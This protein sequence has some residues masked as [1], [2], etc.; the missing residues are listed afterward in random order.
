MLHLV[1]ALILAAE[2]D[3]TVQAVAETSL[4]GAGP[5]QAGALWLNAREPSQSRLLCT[6]APGGL[7]SFDLSGGKCAEA[8]LPGA[9]AMDVRSGLPLGGRKV[10]LAAVA[11]AAP[12]S[13]S[14]WTLE[15]RTGDLTRAGT[16]PLDAPPGA[17]A[18]SPTGATLAICTGARIELRTL[19]KAGAEITG[20]ALRTLKSPG[21]VRAIAIDADAGAVYFIAQ[22]KGLC[23]AALDGSGGEPRVISEAAG[24]GAG[25]ALHSIGNAGYVLVSR[26]VGLAVFE[27]GG[28]N[29]ELG[30]VRVTDSASV[31]GC[32]GAGAV[33]SLVDPLGA[34]FPRGV[35]ALWDQDNRGSPSNFKFIPWEKIAGAFRPALEGG[36]ALPASEKGPASKPG[37]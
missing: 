16:V 12:A 13:V 17:V 36:P 20:T 24:D 15:P 34:A 5:A 11:T 7:T 8:D 27:R 30:V 4:P 9:G 10:A 26:P 31:D 19:A 6:H 18:L 23:R 2:P 35:V 33:S 29:R 22:G 32:S 21:P 14:L 25:L 1:L 37:P 28:A 3:R